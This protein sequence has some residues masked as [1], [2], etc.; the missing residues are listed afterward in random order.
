M[1]GEEEEATPKP[2]ETETSTSNRLKA[3]S[4][5]LNAR[6]KQATFHLYDG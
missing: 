6:G 4:F 3:L 1:A 5:W 2:T